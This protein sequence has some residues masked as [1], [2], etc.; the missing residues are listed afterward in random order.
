M[1]IDGLLCLIDWDIRRHNILS[2][3]VGLEKNWVRVI[4]HASTKP[5]SL[6]LRGVNQILAEQSLSLKPIENQSF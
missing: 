2:N 1:E 6:Y 3:W 5:L 4:Y